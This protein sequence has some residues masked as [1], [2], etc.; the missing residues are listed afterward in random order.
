VGTGVWRLTGANEYSGT[1]QV[2]GGTLVINGTHKGTGS[3]SVLSSATL[4]GK[5][6]IASKVTVF[7]EGTLLAG[8]TLINNQGLTLNKGLS[9]KA[10]STLQVPLYCNG[11]AGKANKV[12]LVGSVDINDATLYLDLSDVSSIPD[13]K[14]FVVLNVSGATITGT[15]F[16][17]IVP[18]RPS[19]TQVWDTSALLTKGYLYVRASTAVGV[20]EADKDSDT[21]ACYDLT[22]RRI[23]QPVKGLYVKNGKKVVK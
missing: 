17:T 10:G 1:T 19:P 23:A 8:D 14:V 9:M 21:E 7:N 4:A 5:G 3:V 18:E 22:G 6:S 12:T 11:S 13:D 20:I 2:K 15:G 16:T